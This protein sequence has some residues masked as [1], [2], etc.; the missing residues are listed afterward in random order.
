MSRSHG[1]CR[2]LAGADRSVNRVLYSGAGQIH[3]S[4]R[5]WNNVLVFARLLPCSL[6][7]IILF[8]EIVLPIKRFGN[9]GLTKKQHTDG[10]YFA[11]TS[12]MGLP[13]QTMVKHKIWED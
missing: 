8:E 1:A 11:K 10:N 6:D 12:K 3:L 7:I 4:C 5:G 2:F 9:H 13:F